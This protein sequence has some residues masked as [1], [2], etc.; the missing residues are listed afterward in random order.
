MFISAAQNTD[1][2]ILIHAFFSMII[3]P[4][5]LN[6]VHCAVNLDILPFTHD[7]VFHPPPC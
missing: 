5:I 6:V 1:L 4:G 2:V 3:D 7:D